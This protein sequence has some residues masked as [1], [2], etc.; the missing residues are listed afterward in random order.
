MA[1]VREVDYRQWLKANTELGDR[2]LSDT[3][4]R[5]RR[6]AGAVDLASAKTAQD[7]DVLLIRSDLFQACTPAVRS[8]LK[9]AA[10]LYVKFSMSSSEA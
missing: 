9:R 10:N 8:Q 6:I 2:A 7:V 1:L 5:T 3:L 4:S